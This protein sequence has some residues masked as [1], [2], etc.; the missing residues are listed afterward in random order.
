M[1]CLILALAAAALAAPAFGDT[2]FYSG[3]LRTNGNIVACDTGC[4]LTPGDS[5]AT[6]A[7]WAGYSVSFN[8]TLATD[9]TAITYGFGGGTSATGPTIPSGGF[10]P[11]LSLFDGDGNFLDSTYFGITCPPGAASIG[12]N[13]FDVELNAGLLSA[14]SYTLVITTYENMSVAENNGSGTLSDGFTGLG[15]LQGTENLNYAFDLDIAGSSPPAPPPTVPEPASIILM[16]TGAA[17]NS[18]A[19]RRRGM[20]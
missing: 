9:V 10:E 14:G 15:T 4:T 5:D 12:G 6:W 13:C 2:T 16:L 11:Y 8:L 17:L 18:M 1:K 7:Q 19:A 3:N 20:E